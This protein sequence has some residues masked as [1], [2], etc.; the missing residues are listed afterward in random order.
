MVTKHCKS[1][2]CQPPI[3]SRLWSRRQLAKVGERAGQT[4]F[5]QTDF[6]HIYCFSVLAKFSHPTTLQTWGA[7]LRGTIFRAPSQT[8][9]PSPLSAGPPKFSLFFFPSPA[10]F[11]VFLPLLGVLSLNFGIPGPL[12]CARL[13]FSCCR[14]K[15]ADDPQEREER[16]KIVAGEGKKR[17]IL[18]HPLAAHPSGPPTLRGLTLRGGAP[19]FGGRA[20]RGLPRPSPKWRDGWGTKTN[21]PILAKVDL[22]KVG[23]PNVGQ[24]RSIKVGQNRSKFF[25]QSRFGQSRSSPQLAKV[26]QRAVYNRHTEVEVHHH[27]S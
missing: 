7:S 26:G 18:G 10:T 1:G 3:I 14:S 12:K 11:S 15:P 20:Q 22:A 8:L 19:P 17:E 5:G 27:P 25:G 21:T 9:S 4:D 13:E 23:H 24:S 6:G 2:T 16:K